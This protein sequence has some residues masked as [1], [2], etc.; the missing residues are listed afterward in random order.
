V[1]F[2]PFPG[3]VNLLRRHLQINALDNVEVVAAAVADRSGEGWFKAGENSSTGSLSNAPDG[4]RVRLVNLDS[5]VADRRFPAPNLIKMDI[6]GGEAAAILGARQ[7]LSSY[8]PI[9]L[10]ATH[11]EELHAACIRYLEDFGYTVEGLGGRQ[12][13]ETDELLARPK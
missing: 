6:E 1:A 8:K 10:L 5:M 3:N 13:R 7:L 11:G 4:I 9:L 2:E 12:H